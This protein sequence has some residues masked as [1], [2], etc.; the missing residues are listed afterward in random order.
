V[1]DAEAA[2]KDIRIGRV[3]WFEAVVANGFDPNA[4]IE[5]IALFNKLMDKYEIILDC[6][7]RNMTLCGQEQPAATEERTPTSKAAPGAPRPANQSAKLS[8][9]DLGM[10]KELLVAG[11][12]NRA[13]WDSPTRM[14]LT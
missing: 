1:K 8:E 12:S 2:L 10:I 6:D 11:A 4:Q 3:T 14:Y 13:R 7:P 9:E 5:Q